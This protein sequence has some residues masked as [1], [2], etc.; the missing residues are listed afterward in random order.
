M[1]SLKSFID[2]T[3]GTAVTSVGG[4][5]LSY[6]DMIPEVLRILILVVTL[7]H[8]VVRFYKEIKVWM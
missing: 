1:D 5:A 4:V 8:L 3:T 2:S 6:W 7:A